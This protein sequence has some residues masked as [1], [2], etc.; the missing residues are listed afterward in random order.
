[1][2]YHPFGVNAA[3]S[4]KKI[5]FMAPQK[6][7]SLCAL[8]VCIKGEKV[9][10]SSHFANS[11]LRI[12]QTDEWHFVWCLRKNFFIFW[13]ICWTSIRAYSFYFLIYEEEI[14][15]MRYHKI[16]CRRLF[17]ACKM[18]F[19][20]DNKIPL[21]ISKEK[22]SQK[23]EKYFFDDEHKGNFPY[24]IVTR[25]EPNDFHISLKF[26]HWIELEGKRVMPKT[27]IFL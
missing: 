26:F 15:R 19:V 22:L 18:C 11:S 14:L 16:D 12:C 21:V 27:P 9:K 10:S 24:M 7:F 6:Q 17:G 5:Y 1:M 8:C 3:K 25:A 2:R 20:A 4:T 23:Y 13:F